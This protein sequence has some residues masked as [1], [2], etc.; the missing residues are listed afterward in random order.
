MNEDQLRLNDDDD[1][2][3]PDEEADGYDNEEEED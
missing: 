3:L 2:V 1:E